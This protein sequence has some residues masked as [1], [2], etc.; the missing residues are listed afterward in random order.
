MLAREQLERSQYGIVHE[1]SALHHNG[2]SQGIKIVQSDDAKQRVFHH[3]ICATGGKVV[4][5]RAHFLSVLQA[6]IH[7]H[8]AFCSQVNRAFCD[9]CCMGETVFW[10]AK[11]ISGARKEGAAA[12]RARFV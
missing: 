5:V 11:R 2:V 3:G 6:G 10:Q 9:K 8:R 1:G 4:C 7:E 12:T